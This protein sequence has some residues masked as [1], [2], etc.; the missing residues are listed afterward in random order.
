MISRLIVTIA[1]LCLAGGS[2]HGQLQLIWS[3]EFDGTELNTD[4]WS[5]QIGT[6][7]NDGL[8]AGWGNNELQYYTDRP[9]NVFVSGG[10]LHIVA[11]AE[12]FGGRS[13]TSA[14]IRTIGNIDVLYGRFEARM[15]LPSGQGIWPAFWMLP[16][17]NVYGTWAASG[18]IDIMESTNF[19]DRIYGTIHFGNPWPNNVSAGNSYAPGTDYGAD[20]HTYA[21]EWE[22][23]VMRWYVD[24]VLYH[25][26]TSNTWFSSSDPGNNRAPFD[27]PFH[28]LLNVAVGGNFPGPPNGSQGFPME[29]VV[30]YVRV[31]GQ[32]QQPFTPN[33]PAPIPGIIEAEDFD[34]GGSFFAYEDADAS[35]NGGQYRPSEAV[36]IEICTEGGFNIGWIEPAEWIEYTVDV[37]VDGHYELEVRSASQTTGGQ[38][39]LAFDGINRTGS[40]NLP[41]TGDWQNWTSVT[42]PITIL[43]GEQIMRFTSNASGYNLNRYGFTLLAEAGDVNADGAI[44]L[45]DMYAYESGQGLYTDIDL[46]SSSATVQDRA[47]L[48][49]MLRGG[50]LSDV[51]TR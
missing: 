31:Y 19:A 6:G 3:D 11:R 38:L 15:K 9:E 41:S 48:Q 43:A 47:A 21:V 42:L 2:A 45:E 33:T 25:V 7:T 44:D 18:E 24:D 35:N 37:A 46:D 30:D 34:T 28:F 17:S 29:L 32:D 12:S 23:D 8:P 20:F 51:V 49:S 14:R 10:N 16:S 39:S 26:S 40:V 1:M 13:Y 22:P 5:A 27:I 4:I 36:D 50:E